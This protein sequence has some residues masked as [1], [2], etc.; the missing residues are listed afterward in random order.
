MELT[1]GNL[2]KIILGILVFSVVV[3]GVYYFFRNNVI[4]FFRVSPELIL[5]ILR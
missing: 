1:T 3:F 2:I 5:G 4:E